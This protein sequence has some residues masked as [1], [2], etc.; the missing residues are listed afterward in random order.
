[1]TATAIHLRR[2]VAAEQWELVALALLLG[3]VQVL[4]RVPPEAL[5]ALL[6]LTGGDDAH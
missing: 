4:R 1:M 3:A 2:A 5:P 6:E